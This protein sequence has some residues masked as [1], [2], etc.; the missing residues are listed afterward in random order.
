MQ[1]VKVSRSDIPGSYLLRPEQ[2]AE[3]YSMELA[4]S[5]IGTIISLELVSMTE[6]EFENIPEF[7]GW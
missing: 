4:E 7:V 6:E 1:F 3:I 2:L 5:E